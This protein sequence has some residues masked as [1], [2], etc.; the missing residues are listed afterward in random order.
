MGSVGGGRAGVEVARSK[1]NSGELSHSAVRK[2]QCLAVVQSALS[3]TVTLY[4]L[5][6]TA[7]YTALLAVTSC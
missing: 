4:T 1:C 5:H 6:C 7:L 2:W 3:C